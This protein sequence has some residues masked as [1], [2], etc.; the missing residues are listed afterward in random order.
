MTQVYTDMAACQRG[1]TYR[2]ATCSFSGGLMGSTYV[3]CCRS[4]TRRS[5]DRAEGKP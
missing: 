1:C 5:R 2:H 4:P 3:V